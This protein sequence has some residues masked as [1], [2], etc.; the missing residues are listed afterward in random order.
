MQAMIRASVILL[1]MFTAVSP[2]KA[3]RIIEKS[4]VNDHARFFYVDSSLAYQVD[5]ST[6]TSKDI[7][8]LATVEG[9]YQNEIVLNI[10]ESGSE[11]FI[12]TS[13]SPEFQAKNDKLSAHKVI[14]IAL[15]MSIPENLVLY[16]KGT[17]THMNVSGHYKEL[18]VDLQDGRCHLNNTSGAIHVNT[19]S[20]DIILEGSHG[21][22]EAKSEYGKVEIDELPLSD[23]AFKLN[24]VSG[25]IH[26][27]RKYG[28]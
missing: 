26:V 20:G 3:Q 6:N 13:F 19:K 1:L 25:N 17:Y 14:S 27:V 24:T 22:V 28:H 18:G 8:I 21:Y 23:A 16:L 7:S 10:E 11:I 12:S 5:I 15:D 2:I 9:E 4:L